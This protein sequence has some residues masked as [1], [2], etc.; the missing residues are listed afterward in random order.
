MIITHR[1]SH[2]AVNFDQSSHN[3]KVMPLNFLM[4]FKCEIWINSNLLCFGSHSS[5]IEKRKPIMRLPLMQPNSIGKLG[6]R[7]SRISRKIIRSSFEHFQKTYIFFTLGLQLS[8]GCVQLSTDY[9]TE[10]DLD[11]KSLV[12]MPITNPDLFLKP[13]QNIKKGFNDKRSMRLQILLFGFLCKHR[14]TR[15]IV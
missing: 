10:H 9:R 3:K 6:F 12:E 13:C 7:E 2:Y 14:K 5:H 15:T 1:K 11:H 4:V 8:N